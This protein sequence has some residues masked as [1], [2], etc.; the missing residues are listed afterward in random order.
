MYSIVN[1][2]QEIR[3]GDN[4]IKKFTRGLTADKML[5]FSIIALRKI[6]APLDSINKTGMTNNMAI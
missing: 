4:F 2:N 6:E 5:D 3:K 1:N